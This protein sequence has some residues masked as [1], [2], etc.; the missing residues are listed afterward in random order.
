MI[1]LSVISSLCGVFCI[2]LFVIG[3][4]KRELNLLF[5][6]ILCFAGILL[7]LQ[8]YITDIL[9]VIILLIFLFVQ[10]KINKTQN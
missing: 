8:G 10:Y 7:L 5:R 9:G 1:F 6:L 3:F 2:S 4:F